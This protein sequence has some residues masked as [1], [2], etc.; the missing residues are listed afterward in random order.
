[1]RSAQG[2]KQWCRGAPQL[3]C[4]MLCRVCW[5]VPEVSE[6]GK[7]LVLFYGVALCEN[8]H[9]GVHVKKLLMAKEG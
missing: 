9:T 3:C 7:I 8:G 1:M 5:R 2:G 4:G 6:Q